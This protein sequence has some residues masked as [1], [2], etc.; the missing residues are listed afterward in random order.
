MIIESSAYIPLTITSHVDHC[1][2]EAISVNQP[3][4]SISLQQ[5]AGTAFVRAIDV[6]TDTNAWFTGTGKSLS[7]TGC[8]AIYFYAFSDSGLVTALADASL[9]LTAADTIVAAASSVTTQNLN[10]VTSSPFVKS[11]YLQGKNTGKSSN[12]LQVQVT[13]CSALTLA[14]N[15][16]LA[17]RAD[18]I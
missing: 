4:N 12:S 6:N 13:V 16:Q 17:T 3:L 9:S 8:D 2:G 1:V 7:S 14:A 18:L 15:F 10:V 5:G 11:F